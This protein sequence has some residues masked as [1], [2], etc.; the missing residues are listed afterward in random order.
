M[1]YKKLGMEDLN[2]DVEPE[3]GL[4]A[5]V[6]KAIGEACAAMLEPGVTGGVK[7]AVTIH[8]KRQ[9][10]ETIAAFGE[11]E[12]KRPKKMLTGTTAVMVDEVPMTQEEVQ[13]PL[14]L[15]AARHTD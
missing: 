4:R 6:D 15:G 9:G 7:I 10:P 3:G 2:R 14:P 12:W 1:G 8:L 11:L 13:V 5:Q